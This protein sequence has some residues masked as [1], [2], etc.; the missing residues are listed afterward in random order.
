MLELKVLRKL[1]GLFACNTQWPNLFRRE[2][3]RP[4]WFYNAIYHW[5]F[6]KLL[7]WRHLPCNIRVKIMWCLHICIFSSLADERGPD[8]A[9]RQPLP[10][11]GQPADAELGPRRLPLPAAAAG[12]PRGGA[13]AERDGIPA[14]HHTQ[15]C[16][17]DAI[18]SAITLLN[19]FSLEFPYLYNTLKNICMCV[20]SC[21]C[22]PRK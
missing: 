6:T 13:P 22:S 10:G 9:E 5:R 20:H 3:I 2:P 4:T 19:L 15:V 16:V 18:E 1:C 21:L 14:G 12:H 7:K 11:C 17:V 8:P